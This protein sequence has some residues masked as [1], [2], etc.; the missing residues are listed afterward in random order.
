MPIGPTAR[1]IRCAARRACRA[2][3]G[4]ASL[5][6]VVA[7]GDRFVHRALLVE[8][9]G[10]SRMA[11]VLVLAVFP[12]SSGVD[13]G[14]VSVGTVTSLAAPYEA[15]W[16]RGDPERRM[17]LPAVDED[18]VAIVVYSL[19]AA[20]VPIQLTCSDVTYAEIESGIISL[21]LPSV[22]ASILAPWPR[23]SDLFSSSA[24]SGAA[25]WPRSSSRVDAE[26]RAPSS[27]SGSDPISPPAAST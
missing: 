8:V 25:A 6:L 21:R 1:R 7:C 9:E 5:A 13:C 12:A 20:G 4:V 27:S 23:S 11:D 19:D 2:A 15:R 10:L 26:P 16:E 24:C 17:E 22:L 18:R 3:V 14:D